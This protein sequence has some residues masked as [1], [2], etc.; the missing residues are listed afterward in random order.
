MPWATNDLIPDYRPVFPQDQRYG[1]GILGCGQVAQSAHLPAYGKYDLDV[2]SVWSR[3]PHSVSTVRERF[4]F[5][6][7]VADSAEELLNDPRVQVVD[8]ATPPEGRLDWIADAL[9]AGKHVLAQKP[10]TTDLAALEPLLKEASAKGLRIAVNQNARWAPAWRLATLLVQHGAIGEVVGITHLHDKP[11]PPITGTPYD[12]IPHMLL[13]DYLV[14]WMDITRCWLAGK[15]VTGVRAMDGRVPAQPAEAKTPWSA[16]AQ[17]TCTD[18]ATAQVRVVG[19]V[20]AR[21]PSCPFWIHGTEGT[22]RGS[23]LGGSDHLEL[24][25]GDITNRYALDGQWF[26]D[27]FAGAMGELMSAIAE[28]REPFNS[29]ADNVATLRIVQAAVESARQRGAEIDL[30]QLS[31]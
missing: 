21:R 11:L 23:I 25:R 9:R 31:L 30:S 19:H 1:I 3:R 14:H 6:Q 20:H 10:L 22:L 15:Q 5:V 26:H 4:P 12:D 7:N 13:A 16:S 24:E 2:A 8:I 29:A 27:G 17:I 18:G 28:N